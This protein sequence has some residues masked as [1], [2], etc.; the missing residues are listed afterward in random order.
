MG[1]YGSD[2][3]SI[4]AVQA[5]ARPSNPWQTPNASLGRSITRAT[6]DAAELPIPRPNRNTA[7]MIENVYTVPPRISDSSRVQITS[8]PNAQNPEIAMAA[9]IISGALPVAMCSSTASG[10]RYGVI[11]AISR[12]T[13]AAEALMAAAT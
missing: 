9:Y 8:A 6:T 2:W 12:L 1:Q 5:I 4:H 13:I 10:T 7:R 11:F 3:D